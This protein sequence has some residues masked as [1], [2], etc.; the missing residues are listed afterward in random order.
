MLLGETCV[1][2]LYLYLTWDLWVLI[3][4]AYTLDT[5]LPSGYVMCNN[6]LLLGCVFTFQIEGSEV[7]F[8]KKILIDLNGRVRESYREEERDEVGLEEE[9]EKERESFLNLLVHS[10]NGCMSWGLGQAQEERWTPSGSPMWVQRPRYLG[11]LTQFSKEH[12]QGVGQEV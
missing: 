7:W 5:D 12:L 11:H 2:I 10:P 3:K 9:R 8:F 1:Q 4:S 6:F